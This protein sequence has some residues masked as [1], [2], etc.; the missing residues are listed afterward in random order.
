[1]GW[2]YLAVDKQDACKTQSTIQVSSVFV[3][4][5]FATAYPTAGS[6]SNSSRKC[7]AGL[8]APTGLFI[9]DDTKKLRQQTW[10]GNRDD[11]VE[12]DASSWILLQRCSDSFSDILCQSVHVEAVTMDLDLRFGFVV[13]RGHDL[14]FDHLVTSGASAGFL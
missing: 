3:A 2:N 4:D 11:R 8:S 14:G 5:P 12:V 13:V 1:M 6:P 9:F 10:T 7:L